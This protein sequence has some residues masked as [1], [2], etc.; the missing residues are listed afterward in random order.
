MTATLTLPAGTTLRLT[1]PGLIRSEWIKLR[2]MRSLY[3]LT[4]ATGVMLISMAVTQAGGT[5]RAGSAAAQLAARATTGVEAAQFIAMLL[6][7]F[8][9]SGEFRTGQIRSTF[10]ADPRR[11]RVLAAKAAVTAAAVYVTSFVFTLAAL[12]AVTATSKGR[13]GAAELLSPDALRALLGAPLYLAAVAVISLA[14][15]AAL[16]GARAAIVGVLIVL[17]A[18]PGLANVAGAATAG[19]FLPS[20]AGSSV[21]AAGGGTLGFTS[22]TAGGFALA[23]WA[24][25]LALAAYTAVFWAAGMAALVRKDV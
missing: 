11:T 12:A 9:I 2:G 23:P 15:A 24:G 19:A 22:A 5:S 10:N 8:V 7:T 25:L 1:L 20:G 17:L 14:F 13:W 18:L 16:R 4:L 6:G 21:Y 3:W